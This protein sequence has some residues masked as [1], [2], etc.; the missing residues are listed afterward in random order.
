M[1]QSN[2]AGR[3]GVVCVKIGIGEQD[4]F[5]PMD[6]IHSVR[7]NPE[8]VRVPEAP[9]QIIGLYLGDRGPIPY[10]GLEK[11]EPLIREAGWRCGIEIK[12]TDG[13]VLGILCTRIEEDVEVAPEILEEQTALPFAE[14][15]GRV[16]H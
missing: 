10:M 9:D 1:E 16:A 14:L 12:N 11:S 13:Q 4:Y 15:W 8:L 3:G 5:I 2:G 6:E 7:I